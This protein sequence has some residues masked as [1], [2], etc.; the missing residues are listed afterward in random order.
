MTEDQF[1][2]AI[3]DIREMQEASEKAAKED[4]WT[5]HYREYWRVQGYLAAIRGLFGVRE[6]A[7][8]CKALEIAA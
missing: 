4:N 2:D 8:L 6:W 5:Q 7:R 3:E 1:N